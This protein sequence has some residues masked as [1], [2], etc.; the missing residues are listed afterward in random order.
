MKK[1]NFWN[2]A[3]VLI[4]VLVLTGC[5]TGNDDTSD[6][7]KPNTDQALSSLLR[8][9][10][11]EYQR[12]DEGKENERE[13]TI[14]SFNPEIKD[15]LIQAVKDAG[16]HQ[17]WSVEFPRDWDLQKGVLS[18]IVPSNPEKIDWEIQFSA[19]GEKTVHAYGFRPIPEILNSDGRPKD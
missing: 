5:A 4:F 14:Y 6:G 13:V 19:I 12:L 3:M 9:A 18:W 11:S 15:E 17:T 16:F 10:P 7:G 2:L 8:T 1:D